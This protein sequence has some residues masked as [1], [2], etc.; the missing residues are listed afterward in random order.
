MD[1]INIRESQ[2]SKHLGEMLDLAASWGDII[3]V[4]ALYYA[5]CRAMRRRMDSRKH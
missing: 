1:Y 3:P 2:R 4:S 5:L